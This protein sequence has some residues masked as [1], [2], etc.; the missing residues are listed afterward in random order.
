MKNNRK[1]ILLSWTLLT[2]VMLSWCQHSS[3]LKIPQ[4]NYG[5][6]SVAPMPKPVT[7]EQNLNNTITT[8]KGNDAVSKKELNDILNSVLNT[9]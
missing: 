2:V 9:K 4:A 6:W 7:V 3:N 8:K 5:A 1:L